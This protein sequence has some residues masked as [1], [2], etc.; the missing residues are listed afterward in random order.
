MDNHPNPLTFQGHRQSAKNKLNAQ[1]CE[2]NKI[3]NHTTSGLPPGNR[4]KVS[5]ETIRH[6]HNIVQITDKEKLQLLY[7]SPESNK[8]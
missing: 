8:P 1:I 2:Q 5:K 6:L 3:K 7:I 4:L